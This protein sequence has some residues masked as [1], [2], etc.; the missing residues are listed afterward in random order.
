MKFII[1]LVFL[2]KIFNGDIIVVDGYI[3]SKLFE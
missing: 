2:L 1:Y 3:L